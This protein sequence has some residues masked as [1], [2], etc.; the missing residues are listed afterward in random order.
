MVAARGGEAE[1]R[2]EAGAVDG[3]LE[4]IHAVLQ[5]DLNRYGELVSK[6]QLSAWKLA[7]GFV[8]NSED[9]RD[10]SQNGF[11]KGYR[12]L[13]SFRREARFSTWLYRIIVNECKDFLRRKNREPERVELRAE[14]DGGGAALF[15]VPDPSPD[16][17]EAV[18]QKELAVKM[19]R[20]LTRLSL[21][22]RMAFV[23]HYLH[24]LPQE[25]VAQVMGCRTGTVKAHLFRASE[26]LRAIIEPMLK[27]GV[28]A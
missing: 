2:G 28:H 5:G 14:N 18:F 19:G 27:Q 16:P 12:N 24:G 20:A 8:G 4:I 21:K 15:D 11:V 1:L 10:I 13:R 23:L 26:T 9:A 22:Q 17:R 25:E 6:Y 7:Y 3:D